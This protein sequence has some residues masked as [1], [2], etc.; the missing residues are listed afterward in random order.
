[1]NLTKLRDNQVQLV[2]YMKKGGYSDTYIDK[3]RNELKRLVLYKQ[4]IFKY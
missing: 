1:M 2:E 4:N 3:I